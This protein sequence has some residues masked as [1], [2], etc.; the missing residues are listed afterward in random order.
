[1]QY[2]SFVG[3][4]AP[5]GASS[6]WCQN[7]FVQKQPFGSKVP[8]LLRKAYG[9]Q[10]FVDLGS[11][12]SRGAFA[13]EQ[14]LYA[15]VGG[16]VWEISPSLAIT[17]IGAVA[18]DLQMVHMVNN[19]TQTMLA[20]AGIGYKFTN[21]AVTVIPTPPW[22]TLLDCAY[23]KSTFLALDDDGL[24]TGGTVYYSTPDDCMTWDALDFFKSPSSA[25]KLRRIFVHE[26]HLWVF[27]SLVTQG[28][29]GQADADN[30]FVPDQGAALQVG[31]GALNSLQ[32]LDSPEGGSNLVWISANESGRATIVRLQGYQA[33][34]ISDSAIDTL[35]QAAGISDV[36]SLT[37][38]IEGDNFAQWNFPSGRFSLRFNASVP[39]EH[40]WSMVGFSNSDTGLLEAHRGN[41]HA[42][43]GNLHVFG[44]REDGRL[45][46]MDPTFQ[47]DDQ[48]GD[49]DPIIWIR[50]PPVMTTTQRQQY[51]N[52]VLDCKV[53][54]G[55]LIDGGVG[56]WDPQAFYAYSDDGGENFGTR[57]GRSMG[58]MG[59][60]RTR[61]IW[62]RN[63][64]S[65]SRQDEFSGSAAVET[66]LY[67]AELNAAL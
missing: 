12:F 67:G 57:R 61:L 21:T 54:V 50:R 32:R 31:I 1:V 29:I 25:N 38:S 48:A 37:F 45:W 7:L 63:G 56:N 9:T 5:G 14:Y 43:V 60:Y 62:Q 30:P 44:D 28:F 13:L 3:G 47:C 65:Y 39:I 23:F 52:V 4:H 27:G 58:K 8:F 36:T 16:N 51:A 66:V 19:P 59:K 64:D 24:P 2:P 15:V 22:T 35:I 33:V 55:T 11:G 42:L 49:N 18:N 17:L 34:K 6:Q 41:C 26:G 46:I 10:Q 53:G 20:S 40:A